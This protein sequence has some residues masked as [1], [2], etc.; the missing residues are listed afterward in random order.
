MTKHWI[1]IAALLGGLSFAGCGGAE[2]TADDDPSEEPHD[3]KA[4]TQGDITEGDFGADVDISEGD[5]H[6]R[7]D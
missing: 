2:V 3:F 4:G 6:E 5:E 7:D 1:F